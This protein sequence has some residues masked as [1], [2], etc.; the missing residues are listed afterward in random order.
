[1]DRYFLHKKG[2]I[3]FQLPETWSVLNNMVPTPTK[4]GLPLDQMIERAIAN[5]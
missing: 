4:P 5:P 3:P 1:M 2:K